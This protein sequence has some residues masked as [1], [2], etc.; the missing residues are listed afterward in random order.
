ME[1]HKENTL[2]PLTICS[3]PGRL[4]FWGQSLPWNS[5]Q[6]CQRPTFDFEKCLESGHFSR[7]DLILE[8]LV[9]KLNPENRP[10]WSDATY[11]YLTG[12]CFTLNVPEPTTVNHV[13]HVVN[14][15]VNTTTIENHHLSL[16]IHLHDQN[17]FLDNPTQ[18]NEFLGQ[19][20]F[21]F[22]PQET[23]FLSVVVAKTKRIILNHR[24]SPC[25]EDEH[26]DVI[27]CVE[28][29]IIREIG[30]TYNRILKAVGSKCH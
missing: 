7:S 9:P 8:V 20:S 24:E 17:G 25:I 29:F 6:F 12:L 22:I 15:L 5:S 19:A 30:C 1:Y 27:K 10:F 11:N 13:E 21:E 16:I 4:N 28:E 18:G 14:I 23:R 2:P 26:W 3:F